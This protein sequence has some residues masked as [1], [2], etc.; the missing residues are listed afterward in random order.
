MSNHGY[1]I[2]VEIHDAPYND[3]KNLDYAGLIQTFNADDGQGKG[4]RATIREIVARKR[5]GR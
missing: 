5:C 3:I 4:L 1:T 2:E